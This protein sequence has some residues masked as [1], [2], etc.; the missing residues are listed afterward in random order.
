MTTIDN[1]RR[2]F[3][4][5]FN[6]EV[7][8]RFSF[9]LSAFPLFSLRISNHICFSNRHCP[10]QQCSAFSFSAPSQVAA[11]G[12]WAM[13]MSGT[14]LGKQQRHRS[15]IGSASSSLP[16]ISRGSHHPS[17]SVWST[18]CAALTAGTG[19]KRRIREL[20][21]QE[22]GTEQRQVTWVVVLRLLR[23]RVWL[24]KN[25]THTYAHS[26]GGCHHFDSAFVSFASWRMMSF[27]DG[28][29]Y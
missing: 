15:G 20:R 19:G 27:D 17:M 6:A 7:V 1:P 16:T 26:V 14:R 2:R 22:V 3:P 13:P 8:I 29:L 23:R 5:G 24:R 10:Q 9:A 25:E 18:T 21:A 11:E 4:T 28:F 12:F